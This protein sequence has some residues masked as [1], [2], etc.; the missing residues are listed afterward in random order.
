[1]KLAKSKNGSVCIVAFSGAIDEKAARLFEELASEIVADEWH[2]DLK[3]IDAI[4]S[5]GAKY[6]ISLMRSVRDK[7]K[8]VLLNCPA[9]FVDYCNLLNEFT[10]SAAVR[11][12]QVPFNCSNC[13]S[14]MSDVFLTEGALGIDEFPAKVCSRCDGQMLPEV[15]ADEFLFFL[16][17]S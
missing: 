1:M 3:E 7:A 12:L 14:R 5:L 6:W 9:V 15:R 13:G 11:S 4:N 16:R 17:E 10:A 2:F 8:I